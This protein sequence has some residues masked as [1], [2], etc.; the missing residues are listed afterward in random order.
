MSAIIDIVPRFD[1]AFVDVDKFG[2]PA[3]F[4]YKDSAGRRR[5]GLAFPKLG[6]E[7]LDDDITRGR[8][9]EMAVKQMRGASE[10][11]RKDAV[12]NFVTNGLRKALG[13]SEDIRRGE[14]YPWVFTPVGGRPVALASRQTLD[15]GHRSASYK[16]RTSTGEAKIIEPHA[17]ASLSTAGYNT[18]EKEYG[19]KFYGI[20]FGWT[21]PQQWEANVLG[22]DLEGESQM[23]ATL[24]CDHLRESL[25]AWGNV[26][27][28]IPGFYTLGDAVVTLGGQQYNSGTP[29]A[30]QML[31]R[32]G[33]WELLF[34]RM[35]RGLKPTNCIIPDVDVMTMKLKRFGS[36][37][38]GPSV[39][40][41]AID[42]FPWL[43]TTENISAENLSLGN[44]TKTA[45]RW[46]LY[47]PDHAHIEH[48]ETMIFVGK[49][50]GM[51]S[52]FI[53]LRRHGGAQTKVP[54]EI[55]YI[56]FTV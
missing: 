45:S 44:K 27:H 35:N 43:K 11:E 29:T 42:L 47:R 51:E 9:M 31:E 24:A 4:A 55:Q 1:A 34:K 12:D 53:M 3:E 52:D 22:E 7:L 21:I 20:R 36:D 46:V 37:Q 56:D 49:D 2:S 39:W 32:I 41:V 14:N 13:P 25:A 17:V 50:E 19:A 40:Q 18:E 33:Y 10:K 6:R 28:K 23:A 30:Q 48:T 54:E 38:G 5:K 8:L 16:I 26:D 15:L